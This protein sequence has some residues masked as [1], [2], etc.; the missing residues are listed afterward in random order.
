MLVV[1]NQRLV[2]KFEEENAFLKEQLKY[3]QSLIEKYTGVY[4]MTQPIGEIAQPKSQPASRS[5]ALS[6]LEAESRKR[7][8]ANKLKEEEA[9]EVAPIGE[10]TSS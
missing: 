7:Y 5:R 1:E 4:R 2:E 6:E 10:T 3:H 8:W 9:K